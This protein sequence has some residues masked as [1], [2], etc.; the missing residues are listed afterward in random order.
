MNGTRSRDK[1]LVSMITKALSNL[2]ATDQYVNDSIK[3]GIE[4]R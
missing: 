4:I 1:R 2:A 3:V